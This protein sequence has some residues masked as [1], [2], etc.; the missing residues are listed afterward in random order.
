MLSPRSRNWARKPRPNDI[1]LVRKPLLR[2]LARMLSLECLLPLGKR[3]WVLFL[4]TRLLGL[5]SYPGAGRQGR[6]PGRQPIEHP[7]DQGLADFTGLFSRANEPVGYQ[8][9]EAVDERPARQNGR[10]DLACVSRDIRDRVPES[11]VSD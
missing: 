5:R 10:R 7:F 11:A 2:S 6:A 8:L 3:A 9:R 1:T 4:H